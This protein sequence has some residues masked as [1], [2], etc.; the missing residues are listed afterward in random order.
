LT[1]QS[2]HIRLLEVPSFLT[3]RQ[4]IDFLLFSSTVG[5]LLEE[6]NLIEPWRPSA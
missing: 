2:T 4:A 6:A 1:I 5:L 3:S